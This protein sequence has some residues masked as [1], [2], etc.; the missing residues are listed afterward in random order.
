MKLAPP[1]HRG[2]WRSILVDSTDTAS[3][4]VPFG[5]FPL[6]AVHLIDLKD[7]FELNAFT[8]AISA[9]CAASVEAD[10]L[11]EVRWNWVFKERPTYGERAN[12][13][14]GSDTADLDD[15]FFNLW[16]ASGFEE[17]RRAASLNFFIRQRGSVN[18]RQLE[19]AQRWD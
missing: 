10:N 4:N 6:F 18:Q 1:W 19:D 13:M 11:V 15:I 17:L 9:S 7:S 3:S 12:G 8:D 5:G 14:I 2:E 16:T